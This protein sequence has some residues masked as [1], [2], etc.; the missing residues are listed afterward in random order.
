M[1]DTPIIIHA[2]TDAGIDNLLIR[3]NFIYVIQHS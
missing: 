1:R 3:F 2:T